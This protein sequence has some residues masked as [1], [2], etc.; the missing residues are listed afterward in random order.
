MAKK[1]NNEQTET[2]KD[3][4]QLKKEITQ[5]GKEIEH[6]K[7]TI[8]EMRIQIQGKEESAET[9]ELGKIFEDVSE[10]LDVGFSIF[11]TSKVRSDKSKGKGL[12]GLIN[13]LSTL[14]EKS[15]TYQKRVNL[16]KRGV[17]DF[18]V[19]SRPIRGS[20]VRTPTDRLKI[21]KPTKETTTQHTPTADPITEKEPIVDVFEEEKHVRVTAELPDVT[22]DKI[23]LQIEN[24]TL[25]ISIDT[26]TR[27][28]YKQIELPTP[29]EKDTIES[30]YRNGIL[31]VKLSKA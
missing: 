15:E 23:H 30:S 17:L 22:K 6:L 28:Y 9:A 4:K 8:E 1:E 26:P 29:I 11:G 13:D 31:E 2:K 12:S 10:L 25:I 18:R 21:S 19:S 14:V 7:K 16:G 20:Y 5:K 27:K 3:L 24:S